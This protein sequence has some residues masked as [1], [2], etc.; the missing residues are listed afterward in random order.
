MPSPKSVKL[1]GTFFAR[2]F[3]G[4]YCFIGDEDAVGIDETSITSW[5][6]DVPDEP[7]IV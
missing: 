4:N 1:K 6:T 3:D 5:F 2:D 7:V